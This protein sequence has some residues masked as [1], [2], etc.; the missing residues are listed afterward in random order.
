M[1]EYRKYQILLSIKSTETLLPY[2]RQ[3]NVQSY[4]SFKTMDDVKNV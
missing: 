2:R 4:I 3:G 1:N